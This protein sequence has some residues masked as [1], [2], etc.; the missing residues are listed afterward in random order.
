MSSGCPSASPR[1]VRA[2]QLSCLSS[3]HTSTAGDSTSVR[4]GETLVATAS[5]FSSPY[6]NRSPR[7]APLHVS[8]ELGTGREGTP[9][10]GCGKGHAGTVTHLVLVCEQ[11]GH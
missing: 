3:P 1:E 5:T 10:R 6:N 11:N 7:P 8:P 9:P 2:P 4:P